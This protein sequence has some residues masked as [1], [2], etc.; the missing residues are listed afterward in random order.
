MTRWLLFAA[1]TGAVLAGCGEIPAGTRT[2]AEASRTTATALEPVTEGDRT[3]GWVLTSGSGPEGDVPV[4]PAHR[5]TLIFGRY[6]ARGS[7]GGTSGCN[8][9]G[10]PVQ[11]EG[12]RIKLGDLVQTLMLCEQEV[13]A[14]EEA[15]MGALAHVERIGRDGDEL[16]LTGPSTEL[17]FA[18]LTPLPMDE[19]VDT[20]WRL[21]TFD[22]DGLV[23]AGVGETALRL[24]HGGAFDWQSGCHRLTGKYIVSVDQITL[25][26]SSAR[27]APGAC[28]PE[29][30][31][32]SRALETLM[33]HGIAAER[34]GDM[35]ALSSPPYR[36]V[37]RA[38]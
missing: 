1:A 21:Q 4:L 10:G 8:D 11:V 6:G 24:A 18:R 2:Q 13:A 30:E 17:R 36:L 38:G 22:K 26:R 32:Q 23:R 37:F 25:T 15:Y 19:L 20:T 16:V 27:D 14:S 9:Y 28:S 29:A 5:T 7:A 12:D 31:E 35:L 34:T 33:R 3:A